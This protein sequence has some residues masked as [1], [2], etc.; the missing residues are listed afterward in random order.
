MGKLNVTQTD[1]R[2]GQLILLL[3]MAEDEFL[4]IQQEDSKYLNAELSKMFKVA[5]TSFIKINDRLTSRLDY[6]SFD[7]LAEKT[8]GLSEIVRV[9][10]VLSSEDKEKALIYMIELLDI[11]I[12]KES[13][14]LNK[15]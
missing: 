1:R 12:A 15:K 13:Q 4:K 2:F 6:R 10:A 9:G 14:V 5:Q 11:K 8:F 3:T 7:L